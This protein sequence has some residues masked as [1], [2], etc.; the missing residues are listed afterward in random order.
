[1]STVSYSLKDCFSRQWVFVQTCSSKLGRLT[2]TSQV[3]ELSCFLSCLTCCLSEQIRKQLHEQLNGQII[4]SNE[5]LHD[6]ELLSWNKG[7]LFH[8]HGGRVR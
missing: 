3:M 1:M 6:V 5:K 7:I 2:S 4:I 8:Y